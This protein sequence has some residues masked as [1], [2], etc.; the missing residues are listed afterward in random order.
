MNRVAGL[1][2]IALAVAAGMA[3][4]DVQVYGV[5]DT[6]LRVTH[7]HSIEGVQSSKTAVSQESAQFMPNLFGLMGSEDLGNGLKVGFLL[8]N[9]FLADSGQMANPGVLFD[10]QSLLMVSGDSW[11]VAFGRARGLSS[12]QGR[13]EIVTAL[14]PF[15]GG[16]NEA[17]TLGTFANFGFATSNAVVAKVTPFEGFSAT[18][19]YSASIDTESTQSYGDN[20]HYAALGLQ[21]ASG[22]L[23]AAATYEVISG[24]A[25]YKTTGI[26][27]D[28]KVLK[29]GATYDFG[30]FKIYGMYSYA[31]DVNWW[32]TQS[33]SHSYMLGTSVPAAGGVVR[34]SLQWLD[35][36]GSVDDRYQ[37]Q[38]LVA[39]LG[40]T[41]DLSK[42]TMLWGIYSYSQGFKSLDADIKN[43]Y[44][45]SDDGRVEAN[46]QLFSLGITHFF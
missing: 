21:Y 45:Q 10:N 19:V 22:P 4:A 2:A 29:V 40:Y 3:H 9:Y 46:R 18:G 14:D 42:R 34:A 41:Y 15:I 13:Y 43:G 8:E 28:E 39:S 23:Y 12:T 25:D 20:S 33:D 27:D 5:I 11:E 17:G 1:T 30:S 37:P 36:E 24:G 26:N 44:L 35:G 7:T 32:G 16:W 31:Q 38:R 6:G